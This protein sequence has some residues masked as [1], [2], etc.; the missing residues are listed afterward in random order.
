MHFVVPFLVPLPI[1]TDSSWI[2]QETDTEILRFVC[3]GLLDSVFENTCKE[4]EKGVELGRKGKWKCDIIARMASAD[5][6]KSS[7][8]DDF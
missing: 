2:L 3:R 6:L 7:E 8:T 5:A 4:G 1:P